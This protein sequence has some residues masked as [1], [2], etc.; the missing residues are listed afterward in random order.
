MPDR[1][2]QAFQTAASRV[3]TNPPSNLNVKIRDNMPN[4]SDWD[5]LNT[6]LCKELDR[7]D[8]PIAESELDPFWKKNRTFADLMEYIKQN[9]KCN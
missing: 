4:Q 6:E 2:E 9:C 8:C 5:E 3:A 1:C 7:I